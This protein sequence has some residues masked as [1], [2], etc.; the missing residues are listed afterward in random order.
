M[1][2]LTGVVIYFNKFK[3]Y[4]NKNIVYICWI[5][6]FAGLYLCFVRGA[7]IGFLGVGASMISSSV[8]SMFFDR[9]GSN[10]QRVAFYQAAFAAA[11][12]NPL[13]GYGYRNFEPNVSIIKNRHGISY[14]SV[15]GHTHNNILEHLAST[16]YIGAIALNVFL[17]LWLKESCKSNPIVFPF[18]IASLFP[19]RC[20]MP[21]VTVRISL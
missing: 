17:F 15:E 8:R 4:L 11:S 3:N 2:L 10:D 21:L 1:V 20:S 13:L 9:Q 19:R 16:G 14:P 5:I 18:E 7:W 12:E 6:N